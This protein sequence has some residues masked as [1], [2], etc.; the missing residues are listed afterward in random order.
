MSSRNLPHVF[1]IPDDI[2]STRLLADMFE[3]FRARSAPPRRL[4]ARY[5]DSFDWRLYNAGLVLLATEDGCH[6]RRLDGETTVHDCPVEGE[7]GF[8]A[9][10][11]EG[12]LRERL[13][14]LLEERTL[15]RM[16]ELDMRVKD[17]RLLND[18][19]KTVVRVRLEEGAAIVV[20]DRGPGLRMMSV[21]PVRGY[22]KDAKRLSRF[23]R[24]A[25]LSPASRT[26]FE[27]AVNA[28]GRVP[29]DYSSKFRPQL[30]PEMT[31]QQ[32]AAVIFEHL[33]DTIARNEAGIRD[34]VDTE[35]LHDFRVA[36]R[37][38][39]SALSLMKSVFPAEL[40][41][42]FGARFAE[43]GRATNRLRDLDVYLLA[44]G[45]YR[46][47]V[48][49]DLRPAL[50][51]LF[52]RLAAEREREH[53]V[54]VKSLNGGGF[55]GLLKDWRKKVGAFGAPSLDA[56]DATAPV[57]KVAGRLITARHRKVIRAG[58]RIIDNSPDEALHAL[59]IDC[60]KLRYL[61]E[62]YSSLYPRREI[63]GLIKQLKILQDNLGEFN[64]LYVQRV[65]LRSFLQKSRRGTSVETGAAIGELVAHLEIRQHAV[66]QDFGRA[67]SA[68]AA[69]ANTK[70]FRKLFG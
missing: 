65:E 2:K 50:D 59:R 39:R 13:A 69:K 15:L 12:A 20:G 52:G 17:M 64:D 37:R 30:D 26:A 23:L 18:D 58:G 62:F 53:A 16:G 32:A 6:L 67:F 45:H 60:K 43:L 36:I 70:R 55:H 34:D 33:V 7:P 44:R 41:R 24:S 63:G 19:D 47:M 22:E 48:E 68:F 14:K 31:A 1:D 49:E 4:R 3:Q 40:A 56:P 57:K 38:T 9:D 28:S 61:L 5:Y 25:G 35:F 27:A 51:T 21:H 66:R 11:P 42:E 29:G 8:W 10:L 46:S 54:L